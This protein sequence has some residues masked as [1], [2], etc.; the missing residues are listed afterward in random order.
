M[1]LGE[2]GADGR[3]KPVPVAGEEFALDVD[4]VLPATGQALS[5]DIDFEKTAIGLTQKGFIKIIEGTKTRTTAAGI[6]AG[7]DAVR[8]PDTVVGAIASGH[9]AAMEIDAALRQ[10]RGESL[11]VSE[12]AEKIEIPATVEADIREIPRVPMPEADIAQ[13]T[14]GFKEV[15]L[16]FSREAALTESTRC[17]RCDIEVE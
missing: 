11:H 6:F 12:T 7:G 13:R 9:R 2:F 4:L 16:G 10:A 1:T 15:E 8:G 3:R 17:L 5:L 14:T